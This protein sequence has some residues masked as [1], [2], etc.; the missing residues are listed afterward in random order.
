MGW[1]LAE[2]AGPDVAKLHPLKI[3]D[4]WPTSPAGSACYAANV[5]AVF[6]NKD[7]N[8]LFSKAAFLLVRSRL[9]CPHRRFRFVL[10]D[11]VRNR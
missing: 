7:N 4:M 3:Y 1:I 5:K 8:P 11:H 6:D 9:L 2:M 10:D